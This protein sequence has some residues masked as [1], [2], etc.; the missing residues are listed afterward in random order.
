MLSMVVMEEEK[1]EGDEDICGWM[2]RMHY[3]IL[4]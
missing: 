4:N 2:E 3:L 1:E